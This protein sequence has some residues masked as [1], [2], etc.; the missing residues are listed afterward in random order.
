MAV[1]GF[2]KNMQ[3]IMDQFRVR[4]SEEVWSKVEE[5]IRDK[6]RKRRIIFLIA[7]SCIGLALGGYGLYDLTIN[8]NQKASNLVN[9]QKQLTKNLSSKR[10][11]GNEPAIDGLKNERDSGSWLVKNRPGTIA[12]VDGHQNEPVQKGM[13][14]SKPQRSIKLRTRLAKESNKQVRNDTTIPVQTGLGEEFASVNR[15]PI[16][17]VPASHKII[18]RV[19]AKDSVLVIPPNSIRLPGINFG[20]TAA[21]A[22]NIPKPTIKSPRRLEWGLNLSIGLSSITQSL[23]SLKNN[24]VYG[25]SIAGSSP[26]TNFQN[27]QSSGRS[28]FGFK[29]GLVAKKDL[30]KRSS[31]MVG[32]NYV[33]LS[34]EIK[35]G[36]QQ[37]NSLFVNSSFAISSYYNNGQQK[38][39]TDRFHFIELPV[40]YSLRLTKNTSH[41][42]ALD[43]GVSVAYLVSADALVYDSTAGGIYYYNKN[44]FARTHINFIP[45]LSYHFTGS[46]NIEWTLGTQAS[47]D[48]IKIFKSNLDRRKYFIYPGI[49]ARIFF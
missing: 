30:T 34:D 49:D 19:T 27:P 40:Y 7:L 6:K 47:F 3:K 14:I 11:P 28:S 18:A 41:F 8:G 4:P 15:I 24:N 44:L 35:T 29:T 20:D 9:D 13:L 10:V 23:F 1:D 22:A 17:S 31:M 25:N 43:E 46:K 16:Q 5:K 12:A 48:V 26:G 38:E 32:I 21:T 36:N 37:N 42:L 45:G 39:F 2:E 33:Y